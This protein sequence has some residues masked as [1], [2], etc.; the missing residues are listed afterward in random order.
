MRCLIVAAL[1]LGPLANLYGEPLVFSATGC[2]PYKLEE[3]PLLVK[4]IQQVN[5]DGKSEFLVHL[6]DIVSG[7]KK[8]WPEAQ[9]I[10]VADILKTSTIPVFVLPGDNEWN[11]L[12]NPD[13]GWSY[14]AKHFTNFEQHFKN[15]PALT[16]QRVRPEN[17]AFESKGVLVIGINL[18][19]G[20]VHDKKEWQKRMQDDA[21]WVGECLA[22]A[23]KTRAA[24]VC[25][26][27]MP[28]VTVEPFFEQFA[29]HAKKY[30]KPVLYLH[31]DGHV[32]TVEKA[33]KAAN[34]TR[35]QTDQVG[36]NPPVQVTVSDDPNQPF[37]FD[38]RLP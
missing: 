20:R 3:E 11:D 21:D 17:F 16:R 9:Y 25:A 32:W 37:V 13:Q 34:I 24:V 15:L 36:R 33:W 38:R 12:D 4:H 6:G 2:G 8:V 29:R 10:K 26:Q 1:F 27:A 31:A 22:R 14:W 30:S 19:V 5:T 18:V 28:A 23:G 7:T 35:V